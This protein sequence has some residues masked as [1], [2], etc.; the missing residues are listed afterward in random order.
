MK[1]PKEITLHEVVLC[2]KDHIWLDHNGK[3]K[4]QYYIEIPF[5]LGRAYNLNHKRVQVKIGYPQ[6]MEQYKA[7]RKVVWD[8]F[9]ANWSAKVNKMRKM[10]HGYI[11][12][13][14][15]KEAGDRFATIGDY[16]AY[17]TELAKLNEKY[18]KPLDTKEN[19]VDED[20]NKI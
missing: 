1:R 11:L 9:K 15:V 16:E 12:V 18:Q 7:D 17:H 13:S 4:D 2:K 6:T 3:Q 19:G 5:W 8:Y 14:K 20:E 10:N